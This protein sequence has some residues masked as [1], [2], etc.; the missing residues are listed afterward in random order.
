[1]IRNRLRHRSGGIATAALLACGVLAS[2]PALAGAATYTVNTTADQ[3]PSLSECSGA[4]GDCSLR[5]AV[6]KANTAAGEDRIVLPAGNYALTIQG[7]GEDEQGD[8]DV[9]EG[10]L[11]IDGAGA[12]GTVV[13]ASALEDRAFHV[14][15]TV[16]LTLTGLTVTGGRVDGEYGGGV[17]VEEGVLVLERV[18]V[19]KNEAI[20]SGRG[21]GIGIEESKTTIS[22]STISGNRNSGDGGGIYSSDSPLSIENSTL[23]NNVVDT[24]LYPSSPNWGAYGGAMETSGGSLALKNVTI[25]GN[26]IF[27]GN[28]GEEGAG[29]AIESGS[30]ESTEIVNTIVYG[31]T[32][33]KVEETGQC[34]ETLVSLDHNLEQQPPAGEPRC[35]EAPTDLIADPLLGPL[36][37]NGGETDTMALRFGSPAIDAGDPVRCPA[38]DQRGFARPVGAGCDIGAFEFAPEKPTI[39]RRGHRRIKAVGKTFL[40]RPGLAVSCP[41]EGEKCSG[42][43]RATAR[44]AG[45]K[46]HASKAGK[47]VSA[48]HARFTVAAGKSRTISFK[49]NR[50]GASMLRE[51][52]RLRIGVE[53]TAR[54]GT[55]KA[56]S[57][58]I[59]ITLKLPQTRN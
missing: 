30:L 32:G 8:L 54:A 40:V 29:T 37:D 18:A 15:P 19:T 28:G 56:V 6:D 31:N 49:L 16:S 51:H 5:Q 36:A 10:E 3:A 39:R 52:G 1:M 20:N 48:G 57:K 41:T 11:R 53:V 42:A 38:T 50:K 12:R 34:T 44:Q 22:G 47:K 55:G 7:A 26:S 43:V 21:G 2:I 4:A 58:K 27:D 14:H 13:D 59:K 23:A 33:T 46:A 45:T 35:F 25:A 17:L 24:S 9:T